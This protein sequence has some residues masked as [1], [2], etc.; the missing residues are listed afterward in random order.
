MDLN[1]EFIRPIVYC[2]LVFCVGI[3]IAFISY[4]H[5]KFKKQKTLIREIIENLT[6]VAIIL[7]VLIIINAVVDI[8]MELYFAFGNTGS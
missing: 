3:G 4:H 1:F 7:F 5:E 6:L 2:F 8:K